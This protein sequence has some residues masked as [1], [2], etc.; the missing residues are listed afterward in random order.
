VPRFYFNLC[1]G[2]EFA[3]D[4]E[5]VELANFEAAHSAAV[6]SLRGVMAGDLLM[7]DLNT[8]SFIEIED[9]D[10]NLLDTVFF[11]K[12]VQMRNDPHLRQGS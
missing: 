8:A 6:A 3:E 7:G 12:V 1:N 2:S 11:D 4:E 9:E 5:G 10:H